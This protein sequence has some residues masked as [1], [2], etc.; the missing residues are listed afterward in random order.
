[1]SKARQT[2]LVLL[3]L[4]G[5]NLNISAQSEKVKNLPYADYRRMHFGFLL[6]MHTQDLAFTHTGFVGE[7]G[8]SWY[9][10]QPGFSPGFSV[11]LLASLSIIEQLELRLTPTMHFG[12]RYVTLRE[13]ESGATQKQDI[14]ANIVAIPLNLKYSS[15]RINNYRPYITA[16]VSPSIDLSKRKN[17][18]LVLNRFDFA[19]D[20]GLG[21]DLYLPYFKLIPELR[22]SLGLVDLIKHDRPD[23]KDPSMIKYTQ[24]IESAKSRSVSLIFYFE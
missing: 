17:T 7:N 2:I 6:G 18:P 1:M 21:F 11:G 13:S 9:A 22:F 3:C 14:K 15:K 12:N 4:I 20:F 10:E 16:G 19:L 23:L 8:E 24:G 5:Y